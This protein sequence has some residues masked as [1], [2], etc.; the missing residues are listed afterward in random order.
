MPCIEHTTAPNVD[1]IAVTPL[2]SAELLDSSDS[3]RCCSD[4]PRSVDIV[5]I[6]LFAALPFVRP[7]PRINLG[8]VCAAASR[9][10]HSVGQLM[11]DQV[12]TL[13]AQRDEALELASIRL[14][15]TL[16]QSPISSFSRSYFDCE[17]VANYV[18]LTGAQFPN[19]SS[20]GRQ[21]Y[22]HGRAKRLGRGRHS[23]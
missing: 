14:H 23:T 17:H 19:R 18:R 12:D 15:V 4:Q 9:Q 22:G 6:A 8:T 1:R 11:E 16:P 21:Q 5:Q 2:C 20:T 10:L 7:Q 3:K 13:R